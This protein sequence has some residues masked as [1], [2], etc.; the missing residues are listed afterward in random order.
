MNGPEVMS[1][2]P[3]VVLAHPLTQQAE[4][5]VSPLVLALGA[6]YVLLMVAAIARR[7]WNSDAAD[8]GAAVVWRP[9][10]QDAP[11]A[12]VRG[13][14]FWA[15]RAV[16]LA[17]FA[18]AIVAG[19][20]G[21]P[22]QLGNIA[23][24]LTIGAGWP[25][26][27]LGA[28]LG[29]RVWWWIN[30]FDTLARP[31][32]QLGAGEGTASSGDEPWAPVWWALVP[33]AL[34]MMYLTVWP[35]GLDPRSIG[36]TLPAYTLVTLAGCLG[37]GRRTWLWRG[38][39]FTVFFGLLAAVRLRRTRWNPPAG[40]PAVLG[41][42]AGGALFG[43]F[44]ISDLGA[45]LVY[46]PRANLYAILGVVAVMSV[47]AVVAERSSRKLGRGALAV[48]LTPIAAGLVL[49]LAVSR[50]RL[51]TSV[52][53]LAVLAS[54]PLGQGLDLFGTRNNGI[55]PVLFGIAGPVWLQAGLLL[56]GAVAGFLLALH[57]SRTMT[58]AAATRRRTTGVILSLLGT[59]L[60]VGVAAAAAI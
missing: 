59:F 18:L 43:L 5:P 55:N 48:G 58:G 32:S 3:L 38:E 22:S 33:A 46:G 36:W 51:M 10:E 11:S 29:G 40:A 23:P 39:F 17:L 54:D 12:G 37:L 14:L 19:R 1:D 26:V 24:A 27:T 28:I 60:A 6:L 20:V 2:Q 56:A 4:L 52:Q 57:F 13:V 25:L 49:A 16:S 7:R 44:R 53:L 35:S 15:T 41:V 45:F 30:P 34:W 8:A 31:V 9:D 21:D 50:S 42:V 47:A